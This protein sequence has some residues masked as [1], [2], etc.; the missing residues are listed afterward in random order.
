LT[1]I[2]VYGTLRPGCGAYKGFGLDTKSNHVATVR[3]EGSMYHLGGFPGVKLDGRPEGFVCDLL[4]LTDP[5]VLARLDTYEGY[6]PET[7]FNSLYLRKEIK[8]PDHGAAYIYEYNDQV[9]DRAL[10]ESGD[11]KTA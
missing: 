5:D 6:R 9:G 4:E 11:W 10:V 1:K 3:I 2:L 7:P 8:V